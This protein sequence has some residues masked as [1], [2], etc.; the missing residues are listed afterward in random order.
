MFWQQFWELVVGG[1]SLD[2]DVFVKVGD[3]LQDRWVAATVVLL[4]GLSQAIGQSIV[5]FANRIKPLRFVLSLC[6]SALVYFVTFTVWV[7]CI[8]L[9]VHFLWRSGFTVENVFRGL[10]VSYA[11]QLLGFLVAAPYFGMPIAVLLSIWTLLAIFVGIASTTTLASWQAILAVGFGWLL[12][13]L[14]QRTIG[15]P[16]A[17]L[18]QWLTSLS[19]GHQV[20]TRPTNLDTLLEQRAPQSPPRYQADVIDEVGTQVAPGQSP[21][22]RRLYRYLAIAFVSFLLAGVITTSQRG[23]QLWF[24]A[25][26]ETVR[27]FTNVTILGLL[28]VGVAIL[29]TP[30]ESLSWWAGWQGDRP[31]N[32]GVAVRD[33][34]QPDE[35]VARYVTYLDG[36]NQ[37]TY[38][39]LPEVERFLAQLAAAL[40]PNILLVKGIIPYSVSNTQL[41][42]DN[43][44]AWVWR[45]VDAFKATVPVVPIGFVV[46]IRNIFAVMMSADAR[47]GPIQNRGLAQ[48]LYDSLIF[49]GYQPG[50]GTPISLIG[51][52][53][54]GQ[55]SMGCV[56]YLQQ[57]TDAPIEV[58][59]IAGVISGNTGAMT[60][61]KLYHLAGD[62]DPVERLGVKLFPARWPIALLS[63]WNKAK[64]RGRIVFI[65]LGELGHSGGN[66][67]M[68]IN[69]QLPDGRTP[70]QQT[71]DIVTGIL[72]K[73]WVRSGLNK[74]D[75]MRPSNYELYQAAPFNQ[76]EYYPL[77]KVPNL[78]LYRPLGDWMGRL[79]L[80]TVEERQT[81]R[82]VRFE[83]WCAPLP[84][85]H[86]IGQ[87]VTLRWSDD[88]ATQAYVQLVTMDVYFAEQVVVSSRQGTVHPDRLNHW[89]KVDPL[90]SIAGAHPIDDVAVI[91]PD[92]VEVVVT[93]AQATQL[94]IKSDPVHVTGRFYG[95]VQILAA[96]GDDRFRVRHYSRVSHDFNG[97]E[98]IVYMPSVLPSRDDR[99]QSTTRDIEQSPLNETGWYIYGALNDQDEFVVQAIAPCHLFDLT[100]DI[101]LT[102]PKATVRYINHE[103]W[104][105]TRQRKGQVV[106][107][108]L[109][110][111]APATDSP[112]AIEDIWREG[113]RALLMEVYGGIGGHKKEFAPGGVYFGHFSFGVA[114][115]IREPLTDLLRFDIEYRQIFTHSS[116]GVVAGSN[117]WTRFMGDRQF[118]RVGLRPV[119]DV[120]IKFP[121]FTEDYD[122]DGV[123]FSP[124][125]RLIHELDVMSAR[126]R[127]GDG[128]GTTMVS[129]INS[130]VQDSTQALITALNRLVAEFQLNP[131]MLKWLR[132]H[133]DHEQTYRI[134]L[135]F[136]LLKSLESALQPLGFARADWRTGELTLGRF[137]G[138]TPGKTVMKA[139]A[140]W[141]SLLPRLANDIITM[142]FLQLG[143]T[144]WITQAYQV[145][146]HDPDIEPIAPT[147]FSVTVPKIKRVNKI[148]L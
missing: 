94:R 146:G 48:V 54:G 39:Y 134:R 69:R 129:P 17:R 43:A 78:E 117:H 122:F 103:Y 138:E 114:P 130:C 57:V 108:L 101:V 61:D 41:T 14:G 96:V 119:A 42:A 145:G 22:S 60:V 65:S 121:P 132:E 37:G 52:S 19:A 137:A 123:K 30:L 72:L 35:E 6:I 104:Q 88:A 7:L 49:H 116:E 31:L 73:D 90:E 147:D 12:L 71:V 82:Q 34:D 46:N 32:P 86:L 79:I 3:S 51:F 5:L 111:P 110:P 18:E 55:M 98:E 99:Y 128:T 9:S 93:S 109:L 66:G 81:V 144:V 24:Q 112:L 124:M 115:V 83:V 136:D 102:D 40:P 50:S 23:F 125:N 21:T 106:N 8:W 64:R 74:A 70:L 47:Y 10:A 141:R 36:I 76:V 29:L 95:V 105:D 91:L 11:P 80:P 25:L 92:P 63:N 77:G 89:S 45:W 58:I 59:S 75:F 67:P 148:R 38:G 131:L 142:V 107:S 28:A 118:G 68:S 139:L 4:A 62:R 126:Y 33:P 140:S 97:P 87:T 85:A 13:Q 84:H 127:I 16:L 27:L 44:F 1:L 133:P 120:I 53:G 56:R 15:Q 20:T 26:D 143:A 113:D 100:P 135:L 2:P